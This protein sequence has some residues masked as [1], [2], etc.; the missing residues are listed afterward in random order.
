[1]PAALKALLKNL[2]DQSLIARLKRRDPEA[3]Q[4]LSQRF[5]VVLFGLVLNIVG[6]PGTAEDLLAEVFVEASNRIQS[7]PGG[8][9]ALGL[10]MLALA[11][12]HALRFLGPPGNDARSTLTSPVLFKR[13][14]AGD[15]EV[16]LVEHQV[17]S[18]RRLFLNASE[19]ERL[20]LEL[21]WYEGLSFEQLS[22][23]LG[24]PVEHIRARV[25]AVLESLRATAF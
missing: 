15:S 8:D 2:G 21:A 12:N 20:A 11:R 23:K 14:A 6:D 22:A 4:E 13:G 7:M 24:Q 5:S 10:W 3:V 9:I 25:E 18:M 1:M 17:D 19:E 16:T